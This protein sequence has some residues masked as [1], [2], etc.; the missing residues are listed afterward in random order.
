M[1]LNSNR[2]CVTKVNTCLKC[3]VII[4]TIIAIITSMAVMIAVITSIIDVAFTAD[5]DRHIDSMR[6]NYTMNI[7]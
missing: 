6:F 7:R 1:H 3:I 2:T 5:I 4:T